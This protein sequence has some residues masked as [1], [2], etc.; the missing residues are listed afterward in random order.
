MKPRARACPAGLGISKP[1]GFQIYTGTFDHAPKFAGK[2]ISATSIYHF[3]VISL[4]RDLAISK[5]QVRNL[6]TAQPCAI[7]Q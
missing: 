4:P 7:L 1:V 6:L 2:A 5:L 3:V